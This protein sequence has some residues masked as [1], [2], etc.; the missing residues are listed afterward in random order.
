MGFRT[1]AL[2]MCG[3]IALWALGCNEI[4]GIRAGN[5]TGPGGAST[6][7]SS[8]TAGAG[9]DT[10]VTTG[11]GGE[12]ITTTSTGGTTS[13]SEAGSGGGAGSMTTTTPTGD[14]MGIEC[15]YPAI[16]N[17]DSSQV[18]CVDKKDPFTDHCAAPGGCGPASEYIEI[19]C[20]QNSDCPGTSC[21]LYF[22]NFGG[23]TQPE[24]TYCAVKCEVANNELV[25]CDN[26]DECI[27]SFPLSECK[28]VLGYPSYKFCQMP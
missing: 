14:G 26:S 11:A 7:V 21:C 15:N 13:T 5:L 19:A 10:S 27:G 6:S 25:A 17:C 23:V 28:S 3:A 1:Q 12:M 4:E 24:A 9:A 18:C 20:A 16:S 22:V 2:K 8:G